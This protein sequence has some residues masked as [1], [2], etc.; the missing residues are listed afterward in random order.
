[1]AEGGAADKADFLQ[2]EEECNCLHAQ[3]LERLYMQGVKDGA[4]ILLS[5]LCS[6]NKEDGLPATMA[7]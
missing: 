4:Q 1:M 2:W 5:L 3:E 7:I 6:Q